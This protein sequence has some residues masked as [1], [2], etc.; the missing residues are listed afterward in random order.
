M[1]IV[2]ILPSDKFVPD[3]IAFMRTH[4]NGDEHFFLT[5]GDI[6][7]YPY[8]QQS[9]SVH[10]SSAYRLTFFLIK[11]IY[12]A[13][14][15][16]LHST[17]IRRLM[18]IFSFQ[19]WILKKS[20]WTIWGGDLY[21]YV[22]RKKGI[23]NFLKHFFDRC[24]NRHIKGIVTYVRGDYELA[25]KTYGVDYTYYE[26]IGYPSNIYKERQNIKK[27]GCTINILVGN[28]ADPSNNH[29]DAFDK[30]LPHIKR[31]IRI[32]CPLSYGDMTYAEEVVQ[33]GQ[34]MFGDKFIPIRDFWPREKYMAFLETIDI[35]L[36]AHRRQQAMG[37]T[38]SLLGFGKKVFLYSDMAHGRF[39]AEK[40]IK[41]YNP[42]SFML[43]LIDSSVA[44][45]NET[46]IKNYFS[47]DN[48]VRQWRALFKD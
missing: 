32:Y 11:R 45:D 34:D 16:I 46:K 8:P 22:N 36:F 37:N 33:L 7:L 13:D 40:G 12:E 2:H 26:C 3:F 30:V 24:A 4:F 35:A 25:C 39:F 38:I 44:Q 1:K 15:I 28:S 18:F 5:V 48:L 10:I 6:S 23:V 19:P 47:E 43:D 21:N 17:F 41:V 27:T 20:Y 31:D 42:S 9:D 14:K 29:K